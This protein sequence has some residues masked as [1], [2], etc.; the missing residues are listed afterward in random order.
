MS[1]INKAVERLTKVEEIV[2]DHFY[3]GPALVNLHE[4]DKAAEAFAS[5]IP[6]SG[7]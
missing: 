1:E 4:L 3:P 6:W 2:R 5:R 7:P